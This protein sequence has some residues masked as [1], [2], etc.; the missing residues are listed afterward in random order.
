MATEEV[1]KYCKLFLL[2]DKC[3]DTLLAADQAIGKLNVSHCNTEEFQGKDSIIDFDKFK[4]FE[5]E[6]DNGDVSC[7]LWENPG[8]SPVSIILPVIIFV[9]LCLLLFIMMCQN[10][11]E[12][13][14]IRKHFLANYKEL[15]PTDP[16]DKKPSRVPQQ[17]FTCGGV[18]I[19]FQ[20]CSNLGNQ[21]KPNEVKTEQ[22]PPPA[23]D[24]LKV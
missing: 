22:P 15:D 4:Y 13:S 7:T 1:I 9:L 10:L 20:M 17:E 21:K 19:N 8:Y 6:E 14:S 23:H 2:N 5:K 24:E 11:R 3:V 12:R 16:N 18:T